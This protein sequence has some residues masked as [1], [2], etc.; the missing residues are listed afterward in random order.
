LIIDSY[1]LTSVNGGS[2]ILIS[3]N[4][5]SY[6]P[7]VDF[8]GSDSFTYTLKDSEVNIT[9]SVIKYAAVGLNCA[10]TCN[11]N[12]SEIRYSGVG[13]NLNGESSVS[14]LN[15]VFDA[16]AGAVIADMK[17]VLTL[18][19]NVYVNNYGRIAGAVSL[20]S[21]G[22]GSLLSHS[23]FSRNTGGS[24]DGAIYSNSANELQ[25]LNNL[26]IQNSATNAGDAVYLYP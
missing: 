14:I 2:V 8:F 23:I 7:A 17:G 10:A 22:A 4:R 21:V 11:I 24:T 16:N 19:N 6:I 9:N 13:V 26:I 1:D 5:F 15:S 12:N 25:I 20:H 18:N 3:E